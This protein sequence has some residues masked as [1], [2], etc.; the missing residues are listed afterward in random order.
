M[1]T[2]IAH[3]DRSTTTTHA[4]TDAGTDAG[5]EARLSLCDESIAAVIARMDQDFAATGDEVP[6]RSLGNRVRAKLVSLRARTRRSGWSRADE[7]TVDQAWGAVHV[8][9]AR[10]RQSVTSF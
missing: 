7:R 9:T 4:G 6:N 2:T 1:N 3:E 10:T 5:T 8:A